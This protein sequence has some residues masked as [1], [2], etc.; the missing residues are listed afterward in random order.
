MRMTRERKEKTLIKNIILLLSVDL[1]MNNEQ[2]QPQPDT[3]EPTPSISTYVDAASVPYIPPPNIMITR[4]G[5]QLAPANTAPSHTNPDTME[6]DRILNAALDMQEEEESRKR[7]AVE[8]ANERAQKRQSKC[9]FLRGFK[10]TIHIC[11]K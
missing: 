9:I 3:V 5:L 7:R 1:P 11:K 2:P 6:R 4:T 8:N 10:C